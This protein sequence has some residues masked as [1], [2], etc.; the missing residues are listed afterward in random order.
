M[1]VRSYYGNDS[2]GGGVGVVAGRVVLAPYVFL[3]GIVQT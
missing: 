2:K 3:T 1:V